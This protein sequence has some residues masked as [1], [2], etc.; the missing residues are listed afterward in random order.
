[1]SEACVEA[2]TAA[3]T[4][5]NAAELA[6]ALCA[7]FAQSAD[8]GTAMTLGNEFTAPGLIDLNIGLNTLYLISSGA[9]V[10]VMHAGFAMLCAGAIRSKNTMNILLQTIMDAAVSA[11]AFYV[12]G[13]GFAYG[14]GDKPNGF[15]GDALFGLARWKPKNLGPAVGIN[16]Q[17]W[18][19]QWAF[20]ATATTIPA[21]AV[22]ERLNFNAYLIY[23]FF[24]SAFVYPVVVHWVWSGEG[25]LG[26]ARSTAYTHL[27]RSGM[28]DFAG[29][30]VVHMTG[31]LAGFVGCVLVGPR[32]GR[33]DS[34]G[35]PV[36][37]P[38]HSAT[39]VV[40]G[41]VLLWF[42]WYGF[43]PGSQLQIQGVA[44]AAVAG[45][46]AVTTTL[47]GAAGCLSCL[48]TAFFR[49]K[50]RQEEQ[51]YDRGEL[52]YDRGGQM[53][54]IVS[55]ALFLKLR[56]D[57]P[58]SAA[59]MHGFTGAWGVFFVGL[60][61]KREYICES[62]GRDCNSGDYVAN[63]LLYG[64]DGRLLASQVIGIITIA[65]W[66]MGVMSI[67]FFALK[68]LKLLRIS[69]EEEQAGL[70]VSKH[71][72]SAYNYQHGLGQHHRPRAVYSF[73]ISAFVYLVVVHWVWSGEGWLGFA[74]STAYTH[75]FRS[76]MIDFAGSGVV[77]M[78][79]GLAGFVGCVLVGPRMGRFDSNGQPV[80]MPGH[81]ATLVVLGTVLLWFGWYGFN[82]GSQL[83]IQGVANAAVAG[84][85]AV[86]TTLSGAAGC[87]S[88]LLTAFFR[89]K[90]GGPKMVEASESAE[91]LGMT[92]PP[93]CPRLL[94]QLV[95]AANGPCR[96]QPSGKEAQ[97]QERRAHTT[98]KRRELTLENSNLSPQQ[99]ATAQK[100][101]KILGLEPRRQH[102]VKQDFIVFLYA[103]GLNPTD[104]IIDSKIRAFK[105]HTK[106]TFTFGQLAHVWR[107]LSLSLSLR[108]DLNIGLNTL[109]L[110]SSG[111]LV[112]VMHAGFAMLCAGAIRS[113][114]TM[115]ILLQTI[116]DAAV[117]AIAF[118]VVGYGFAYGV[119]DKPNGFI[120]DALFGLARWKPKNLGPAVGINW[121][122]WFFQWAFA[123]TAT[124]IPAGAVAERLN[125]NAYLKKPEKASTA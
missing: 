112:F 5:A 60:L 44:N 100:A 79:G 53:Y 26:F 68:A 73:F 98:S 102:L 121:Q 76:G 96:A 18:F 82:P 123:A 29:S 77:H 49:H 124:T 2:F 86:T 43:N 72:G 37:M 25:W 42:G 104:D 95:T 15:I 93:A 41:T 35:Q 40:L 103:M 107:K 83:Q 113:K 38:G 118:Y 74:R 70:D 88:C 108:G 54:D 91:H 19:F 34:N 59:P 65:T 81:S 28:I 24:I 9:L 33:F 8:V 51:L 116:M 89:H 21:G 47:S 14:V 106:K 58:L 3:Y 84:R 111:A 101:L 97:R 114:N 110:I 12:V 75:L 55:C 20:A 31:G 48:L 45:R 66:V 16:W 109:Y 64:G 22:A 1:M 120:G 94:R 30:G 52:L 32:M 62:Y 78:T 27:F 56:I 10:F 119:G 105:L 92:R 99:I 85:A 36:E 67:L 63:G 115:N 13:Y 87:L 125:F 4:G 6:A 117:S 122:A 61:A 57:D 7:Q 46:A 11:I 39:L 90:H 50:V 17:A 80:E 71:G 23:S 69:A